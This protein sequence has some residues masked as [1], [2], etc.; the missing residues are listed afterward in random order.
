MSY[1]GKVG[2]SVVLLALVGLVLAA[3]TASVASPGRTGVS[4]ARRKTLRFGMKFSHQFILDLGAKG[5]SKG[6]QIISHDAI[7]NS[8]GDRVGHDGLTC[9]FTHPSV[10]EARCDIVIKLRGR[11]SIAGSFLNQPP[12]HKV[13]AITGGSGAFALAKGHFTLVESGR[14]NAWRKNRLVLHINS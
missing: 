10:P 5:P 2:I 4:G 8:Q 1:R 7:I 12:P 13:G 3:V 6:D 9:T 11:G 14:N